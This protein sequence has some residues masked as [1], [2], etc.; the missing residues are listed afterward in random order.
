MGLA[1]ADIWEEGA[2]TEKNV[3]PTLTFEQARGAFFV[4]FMIGDSCV[5]MWF[6][7]LLDTTLG[8]GSEWCKEAG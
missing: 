4:V 7:S 1:Q 2:S 6:I 3:A 8:W 5:C